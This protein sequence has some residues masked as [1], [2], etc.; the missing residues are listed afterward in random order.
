VSLR[1][2]LLVA[3][4][5]CTSRERVSTPGEILLYVDT[6]APVPAPVGAAAPDAPSPLFDRVRI[7]I[8][9][10]GAN[11]PCGACVN[12]FDL[13][14]ELLKKNEASIGV[15]PPAGVD[16]YRARVRLYPRR[17]TTPAGGADPAATVDTTV[18]LPKVGAE[19]KIE[20]T[21]RLRVDDVGVPV[22]TPDAPAAPSAGPPG[23]SL[24]GSWPGARRVPCAGDPR[25]D[26]ACVPGGAFWLGTEDTVID[27]LQGQD[28]LTPHLVVVAPFF[29]AR[30][31]ETVVAARAAGAK[32]LAWTGSLTGE[33]VA[34]YC[35]FTNAPGPR[36]E[37][38]VNC[39]EWHD[40]RNVCLARGADLPTEAQYEYVAGGLAGHQYVW[41]EDAP[42]CA[43]A[44]FGR[45][46]YGIFLAVAP[47]RPSVPPGGPMTVGS[48][49][50]DRL[51][52][53][54]GTIVDLAGNVSE[55]ALDDWNRHDGPCWSTPGVFRDPLCK[56]RSSDGL[57]HPVRGG[58]WL[59]TAGQ[60]ART[61]RIGAVLRLLT[62]EAGFRCARPDR[63]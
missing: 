21:V 55:W 3:L 18:V 27:A 26:E 1:P 9:E 62:P 48:G 59:V 23:P 43:D 45:S 14:V 37:L 33:N 41:G 24:V 46:G 30:T 52:L 5:A 2:S 25:P 32:P 6:D 40:A 39:L 53:P 38:P 29:L 20:V 22:G 28:A 56:G 31:E 50:R 36:D 17:L 19:G 58:Q 13:D 12:T 51:V 8:L 61:E 16:G 35:T 15:A 60:L 34:D 63:P 10:P 44:V 7:E 11:E 57:S 42:E 54:T 4:V 47:C 49:A